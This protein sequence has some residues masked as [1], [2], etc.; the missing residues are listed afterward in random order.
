[1]T[2]KSKIVLLSI[3][4][5]IIMA[6]SHN[7]FAQNDVKDECLIYESILEFLNAREATNDTVYTGIIDPESDDIGTPIRRTGILKLSFYIP[8]VRWDFT[9]AHLNPW[10]SSLLMDSSLLNYTYQTS[11]GGD[12]Q[13]NFSNCLK[14]QFKAFED[15]DFADKD[16]TSEIRGYDT[17]HYRP[18]RVTFSKIL[19]SKN[20]ALVFA[21][22]FSGMGQGGDKALYAF[23]FKKEGDGW[24]IEKSEI[25]M[26]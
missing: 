19:Y 6:I 16:F 20:I 24:V 1:M 21:K 9:V 14:Y 26:L 8:K 15:T 7:S 4:S 17:I 13:C 25:E 18:M 11:D 12:L 5:L 22:I 3:L 23:K 10:F 2:S